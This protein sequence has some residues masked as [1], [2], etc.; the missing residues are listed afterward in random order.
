MSQYR[1]LMYTCKTEAIFTKC[2]ATD[3]IEYLSRFL[4]T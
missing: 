3:V 1:L 2:E 4:E